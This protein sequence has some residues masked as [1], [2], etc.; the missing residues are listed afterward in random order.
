MRDEAALSPSARR[1]CADPA[2]ELYFSAVS[3]WE[4]TAK[5]A[6]GRLPLPATP[7]TFIRECCAHYDINTLPLTDEAVWQL[8]NL[9]HIHRDPFDRM[10]VCQALAHGLVILSPDEH[11]RRYRAPVLW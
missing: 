4:I 6:V 5:N 8:P 1:A 3:V 2:N 9:P 7:V 11:I 10:L